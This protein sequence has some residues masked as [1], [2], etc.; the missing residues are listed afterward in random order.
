MGKNVDQATYYVD[1]ERIRKHGG[2]VYYWSLADFSKPSPWNDLSVIEYAEGDCKL[3]RR[4]ILDWTF[5]RK[6]MGRGDG[7]KGEVIDQWDSAPPNS[8]L[9][10][11]LKSVCA[12]AKENPASAADF[13][14]GYTASRTG[15]YATALR[16][17]TPLA[18]QGNA[19]AQTNLGTMYGMGL[20]VSQNKKTALKWYR[21][22]AEAGVCPCPGQTW[23]DVP[24]RTRCSTELSDCGEVVQTCCRTGECRCPVQSGFDVRQRT[25]CSTE[26][27]T[28]VKWYRLA[29]EQGNAA[30]QTNLD[31]LERRIA[32]QKPA[33]TVTSPVIA[34]KSPLPTLT[35]SNIISY[36]ENG[37]KKEMRGSATVRLQINKA[38]KTVTYKHPRHEPRNFKIVLDNKFVISAIAVMDAGGNRKKLS[39]F[40]SLHINKENLKFILDGDGHYFKDRTWRFFNGTAQEWQCR[41][42]L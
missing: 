36:E 18:Q 33:P 24:R 41:R 39:G 32:A 2:N 15:D 20:G 14:K 38:A 23:G 11:I 13:Q 35:C 21:L 31:K 37:S 12:Y 4:K 25:R 9:K 6:P 3:Y 7:K 22:A 19:L 30:A 34:R 17:W 5:H 26:H 27:K 42:P 16:E 8:I 10:I 40:D 28:A 1:F 29:A